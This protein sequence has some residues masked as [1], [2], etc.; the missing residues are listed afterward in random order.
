MYANSLWSY[1]W[2]MAQSLNDD[3]APFLLYTPSRLTWIYYEDDYDD[4]DKFN[5]HTL[6]RKSRRGRSW[7]E[8]D[9]WQN[10]RKRKGKKKNVTVQTVFNDNILNR[11]QWWS[12]W[13][14]FCK[15]WGKIWVQKDEN[16]QHEKACS[17]NDFRDDW[18][19]HWLMKI[20]KSSQASSC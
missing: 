5:L 8:K 14:W 12:S 2:C 4:R 17:C 9:D 11:Q 7:E 19:N 6:I 1:Q 13:T 20:K 16:F 18:Q 10:R 15:S 3:P